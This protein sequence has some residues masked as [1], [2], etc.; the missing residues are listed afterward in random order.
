MNVMHRLH[1][2]FTFAAELEYHSSSDLKQ[3]QIAIELLNST[4]AF[5]KSRTALFVSC[6]A[7]PSQIYKGDY[8]NEVLPAT[9]LFSTTYSGSL[10]KHLNELLII[11]RD[12]IVDVLLHCKS[13]PLFKLS[14]QEILNYLIANNHP[15]A[16]NSRYNC[17]TKNDV[18]REKELR[19]EIETYIDEAQTF[20]AF[21][22][23]NCV[24]IKQCIQKHISTLGFSYEWSYKPD[25]KNLTELLVT[26]RTKLFQVV[27][28]VFIMRLK[29]KPTTLFLWMAA[30]PAAVF[31]IVYNISK[32]KNETAKYP[33]DEKIRALAETQLHAIINEMTAISP[34]KSG[35]LRRI[36]YHNVLR[37][38]NF[39]NTFFLDVPTVSSIRW[40]TV[41]NNKRLVFISSYAN[42]T[43]FYVRDFLEAKT[44]LGVNFIFTH[45]EGFPD[46]D[47]LY[48]GGI[49]RD[50]EGYMHAVHT[51]Q[52]VTGFSYNHAPHLTAEIIRKNR[53]IRNGLFKKMNEN[54]ARRW[55]RLL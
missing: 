4:Q 34:L 22:Q 23:M 3:L 35:R 31:L 9:L 30:I 38:V 37:F 25:Y 7:L 13:F 10:K 32:P 5:D 55:L 44:F 54:E 46:S 41:N 36:F 8:G 26:N 21:K 11:N 1:G 6:S 33:G 39:F 49:K 42:T 18:E 29:M 47:L 14:D 20:D 53:Q 48:K 52:M 19:N 12:Q 27:V 24:Q 15:G 45:G 50:P 17:I 51:G 16:F 28:L 40:L 43:D 2:G